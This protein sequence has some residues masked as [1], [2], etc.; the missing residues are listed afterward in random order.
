MGS[1]LRIP[2]ELRKIWSNRCRMFLTAAGAGASAPSFRRGVGRYRGV[3]SQAALDYL[4][5]QADI[6]ERLRYNAPAINV[7]PPDTASVAP[8]SFQQVTQTTPMHQDHQRVQRR[9]SGE[10]ST[11]LLSSDGTRCPIC[12]E[13]FT[14]GCASVARSGSGDAN[15]LLLG[16][17]LHR[18][19]SSERLLP[20]L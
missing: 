13:G 9:A 2:T 16:N 18:D 19:T 4:Y 14:C 20:E 10:T 3:S 1:I 8:F 11:A 6:Q 7:V 17:C 15:A 12:Q 5:L